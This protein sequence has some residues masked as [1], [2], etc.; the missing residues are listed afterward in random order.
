MPKQ[1]CFSPARPRRAETRLSPCSVLASFRPSTYRRRLPEIGSTG[2]AFP[3]AKIRSSSERSIRSEVCTSS[4]LH[5]LRP[6]MG[7]GASQGEVAVLVDS[8]RDGEISARAG[9]VSSP[10]FRGI[11]RES[12]PVVHKCGLS[13]FQRTDIVFLQSTRA[14]LRF[15][16][17]E[18][19]RSGV[20]LFL[21]NPILVI[22]WRPLV[23]RAMNSP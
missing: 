11:L 8:G 6:C 15:S 10:A 7:Q 1:P 19:K 21:E 14:M 9:L 16:T 13:K 4:V 2:R 20:K 22:R 3:F 17:V 23:K 5:S 18:V 12:F